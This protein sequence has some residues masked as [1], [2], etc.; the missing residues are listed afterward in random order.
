MVPLPEGHTDPNTTFLMLDEGRL[1][2]NG[3]LH[4]LLQSENPFVREF[5]E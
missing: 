5:L 1:I 3:T 2:F 4:D